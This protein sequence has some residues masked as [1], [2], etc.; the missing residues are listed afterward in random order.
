MTSHLHPPQGSNHE[1]AAHTSFPQPYRHY[2]A[3]DF[4]QNLPPLWLF[5]P[6]RCKQL[7]KGQTSAVLGTAFQLHQTHLVE[8]ALTEKP[9]LNFLCLFC[10]CF[11]IMTQH[12]TL[13]KYINEGNSEEWCNRVQQ[14][15]VV[16]AEDHANITNVLIL[17]REGGEREDTH[18]QGW[19]WWHYYSYQIV[20]KLRDI[21]NRVSDLTCHYRNLHK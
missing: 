21:W 15:F 4:M 9:I 7:A 10:N 8:P 1:R 14:H 20:S 18:Q 12:G 11:F 6:S 13:K 3:P 2:L 5:P 17:E 19:K 16:N